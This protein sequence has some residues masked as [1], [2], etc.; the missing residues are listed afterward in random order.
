MPAIM[1]RGPAFR[2]AC[3]PM[4]APACPSE[5]SDRSLAEPTSP[6]ILHPLVELAC[7]SEC[8]AFGEYRGYWF[9]SLFRRGP[10]ASALQ[11]ST[12]GCRL[13][14]NK[15]ASTHPLVDFS[16]PPEC[17]PISPSPAPRLR[18]L[19]Q[20]P[21]H[22][23]SFPSTHAGDEGPLAAGHASPASFRLQGLVTLLAAYSLRRLAELVSSRQRSWDSSLRS[24]LLLQGGDALSAPSGP[25]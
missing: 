8:C 15:S 24:V 19:H 25:A 3:G 9:A 4:F 18:R 5:Y 1:V 21:S 23:L 6:Q 22:G 11:V 2:K 7:R 16:V 10:F 14:L 13:R 17:V 20:G 12:R